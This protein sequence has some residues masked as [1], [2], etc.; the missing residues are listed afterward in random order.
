MVNFSSYR[1]NDELKRAGVMIDFTHEQVLELEKCAN[2][3]LYFAEKYVKIKTLSGIK[4][5]EAYQ[6]Q[7]DIIDLVDKNRFVIGKLPRQA[8][9][10]TIF[11]I[12][13]V[14]MLIFCD[15]DHPKNILIAANR[16]K[17]ALDIMKRIKVIYKS[18]PK[19]IQ[20]GVIKWNES[21]IELENGSSVAA[22]ATSKDAGRGGSFNFVLLD[23]FA[24]VSDGVAKEFYEAIYPTISTADGTDGNEPAKLCIISTPNGMNHFYKMWSDAVE[25]K[26][27]FKAIEIDWSDVPGRGDDYKRKTIS[28]VGEDTWLQEYECHFL[29]TALSLIS[30]KTMKNI[31]FIEP[32]QK[33]QGVKIF[34]DPIKGHQYMI[35]VDTSQGKG[36]DYSAFCVIDITQTPYKVVATFKDDTL[37]S[38]IYPRLIM[39]VATIYNNAFVLVELNDAG[40]QTAN[41]LYHDLEYENTLWTK[42]KKGRGQVLTGFYGTEPGIRTSKA[43]KVVGCST[44]KTL[45][46]GHMLL[47]ND[48]DIIQELSSFV[49]SGKSFAADKGQHDDLVMCLVNFS[50]ASTQELFKD[51]S[52]SD[53]RKSLFENSEKVM[54]EEL[55][56]LGF[57]DDGSEEDNLVPTIF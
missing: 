49:V 16:H 40:I 14:H 7:K 57:I 3:V 27:E 39:N 26:S 15:E 36:L 9:K 33:V 28:N 55:L 37:D 5:F 46:E 25:E 30:G 2:D 10:S 18:L 54:D 23:E 56:P 1:G 29:G 32:K 6:Y 12:I 13:I 11:G 41:I 38:L 50:W 53:M 48:F 22:E 52:D 47:F 35:S 34:D 42:K 20:Q 45:V 21:N 4:P 8:G 43:T 44:L 19:W 17:S 31:P 24:F 51:L